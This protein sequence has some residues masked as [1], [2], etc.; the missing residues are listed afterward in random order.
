[1]L[2]LEAGGS[3]G[4]WASGLHDKSYA[5]DN[6]DYHY[7]MLVKYFPLVDSL[8]IGL[9]SFKETEYDRIVRHKDESIAPKSKIKR[10]YNDGTFMHG[11]KITVER[12]NTK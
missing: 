5:F 7:E 1:M 10:E 4:L 6:D 3:A 2:E 12:S 9:E 11:E 8:L